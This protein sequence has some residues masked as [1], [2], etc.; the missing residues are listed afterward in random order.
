M[1]DN[2]HGDKREAV[3]QSIGR[4][5]L[6]LQK[7]EGMFKSLAVYANFS[8]A[9]E[10]LAGILEARRAEFSRKTLGQL[11]GDFIGRVHNEE[12]EELERSQR[13]V[14]WIYFS[15]ALI[16]SEGSRAELES[17]L[18]ILVDE[19]NS[20]IHQKL[21]AFDIES[22]EACSSLLTE[23]DSQHERIQPAHRFLRELITG[24][25]EH[26][27]AVQEVLQKQL[28]EIK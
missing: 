14:P 26:K 1:P 18:A 13:E 3:L 5:I 22:D 4:N 20:L 28:S 9:T 7:M 19:R 21:L 8:C 23:L 10:D 6:L 12:P 15:L 24:L 2:I 17:S 16:E 25:S 11:V 27:N